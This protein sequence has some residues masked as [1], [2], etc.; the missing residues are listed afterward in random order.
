[1]EC[2]LHF[3]ACLVPVSSPK[4]KLTVQG[5][6]KMAP[7][8][9]GILQTAIAQVPSVKYALGIAGIAAAGALVTR[10][11]GYDRASI[12][13]I[14]GTFVAMILL[15]VFSSMVAS[16]SDAATFPGIILLYAV[17]F[18]FCCF[19]AFTVTAFSFTWPLPWAIF[20]GA[21]STPPTPP[22]LPPRLT[23]D[24][25]G[26]VTIQPGE[27]RNFSLDLKHEGPVDLIVQNLIPDWTGREQQHLKWQQ[28]G[29]GDTPEL[30]VNI[31]S[32]TGPCPDG[33]QKGNAG[34]LRRDLPSGP[35]T[36]TIFNF[37]ENPAVV[38]SGIFRYPE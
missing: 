29:K 15:Y 6:Y 8:P 1:M 23:T 27:T 17:I 35:A 33:V 11:L 30:F 20:I 28:A 21:A 9:T 36:I 34:T 26:P 3:P 25:V 7:E 2:R 19:L 22:P 4:F 18:F 38:F 13:I 31:C 12:I 10:F 5:I 24:H 16:K 37:G 14:G 32:A